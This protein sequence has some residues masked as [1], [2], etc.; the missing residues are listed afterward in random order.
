MADWEL[1]YPGRFLNK[2]SL[3]VPKVIRIVEVTQTMLTTLKKGK[4]VEELKVVVKYKAADGE[5]EIPW[6]KTNAAL[7]AYALDERDA[8]KWV[9]H[10]V[11]VMHDPS[12]M[13]GIEKLGGIRVCGSPEMK[14]TKRVEIKRPRR[15]NPEVYTLTPTDKKGA[16]KQPEEPAPL[17][18]EAPIEEA[19]QS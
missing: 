10:R 16:V 19:V 18:L 15:K 9:G 7:T 1:L 4:E 17:D 12:I 11:T 14:A 5:G 13:F 2:V 8:D 6:N 3:E